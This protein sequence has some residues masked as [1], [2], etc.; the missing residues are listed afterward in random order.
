MDTMN[1]NQALSQQIF[2]IL[3][4]ASLENLNAGDILSGRVQSLENGLLLIKLLDGSSFTANTPEGF[5]ANVGETVTLEIGERQ[6]NQLTARIVNRGTGSTGKPDQETALIDTIKSNLDSLGVESPQRFISGVLDLIKAEPGIPPEKAAFIVANGFTQDHEMAEILQKISEH[7]FGLHE[8]LH[9]LEEGLSN[10]LIKANSDTALDL[11]KP[12]LVSQETDELIGVFKEMLS[13]A[14]PRLAQ[15][16]EQNIRELITR[17]LMDEL[18]NTENTGGPGKVDKET[19][20]SLVKSALLSAEKDGENGGSIKSE[21]IFTPQKE[22][23]LLKA[24]NKALENIH[25][26]TENLS[27]DD[28]NPELQKEIKEIVGRLFDRASIK[29]D[30]GIAEKFDIKE[31]NEALK[32][33]MDFSQ[34]VLINVDENS[35]AANMSAYKEIDNAFK[36][37]NQ[38]TTYDSI[39]QLPIMINREN[40]TGELYVMKRKKGRRKI[41]TDNFTLFLSLT[42]DSL[43]VVESFLNATHKR[44]TI[45]F[46]VEDESLVKLV[47][48]NYRVLYDGLLE[49]GFKLVDLKCRVLDEERVNPVN[50]AK[51]AQDLLGT[52]IRVDLKI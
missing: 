46:R 51:K 2:Q 23:A 17:T 29:V 27:K 13:D 37:F 32:A 43:G 21:S 26:K 4:K 3:S 7:E 45:S 31:K 11:L 9:S 24:I 22:D 28:K 5:S 44:I 14:S 33:I 50:A 10:A 34:K 8:N 12:L 49:K 30:N 16:I 41:D 15:S 40:T 47:K 39:L 38:V 42:T 36:F 25:K 48:D 52:K 20:E 1:V 35:K 18:A 19:M 6:N